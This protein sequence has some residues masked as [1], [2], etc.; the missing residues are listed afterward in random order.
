M[1][2]VFI[3]SIIICSLAFSSCSKNDDSVAEA[4]ATI[5]ESTTIETTLAE[6][7]NEETTESK[8]EPIIKPDLTQIR[9]IC[10]LATLQCCYN[11]VAKSTKEPGTGV[12]HLFEKQRKFWIEYNGQV[13]IGIDLSKLKMDIS[14][15]QVT[16]TIPNAQILN[17]TVN[18]ESYTA[19]SYVISADNTIFTNPITAEDQS[20]AIKAATDQLRQSFENNTSLMAS[21][22]DRAKKLIENYIIQ[23]GAATNTTYHIVWIYE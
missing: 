12:S 5:S 16:I 2:K 3:A 4:N 10:E 20:G 21:A 11:N 15:E 22:Q 14:D 13:D 8:Q 1:K 7:S 19:D 6:T 9:N 18:P 17:I 23:I